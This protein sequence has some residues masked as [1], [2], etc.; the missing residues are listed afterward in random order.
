MMEF[1]GKELNYLHVCRRKLWLFRHGIRPELENDLVQ[2]GMLLGEETFTRQEKEIPIGEAGVLDWADFKDGVIHETKRGRAPGGGDE[3]QVRYYLA[4]LNNRGIQA[5]EAV[6]HYPR[7]R[8]T[9]VVPWD[10]ATEQMV[11]QDLAEC[12][13]VVKGPVPA[14]VRRP[15]CKNCAYEEICF[16]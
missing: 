7:R 10:E 16:V 9:V 11:K 8:E 1:T 6:I 4:W 2:L 13:E 12:E 3:A 14:A 15:F 5:H